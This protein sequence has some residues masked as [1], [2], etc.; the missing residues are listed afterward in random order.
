MRPISKE[1][2]ASY[3]FDAF[4]LDP[5]RRMLL[6][7]G[8]AIAL[9]PKVFQTLLVLVRNGRGMDKDELMQQVWPDTVVEEVNLAHN[10]SMLRKALG[11][12][13]DENRFI[14]TVPGRGS[15]SAIVRRPGGVGD[16]AAFFGSGPYRPVCVQ[17]RAR[18]DRTATE[19]L[20][21]RGAVRRRMSDN[22]RQPVEGRVIQH[23]KPDAGISR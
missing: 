5:V 14:I 16:N 12:K 3:Q 21:S 11:Q 17:Y 20:D 8:K 10:I 18:K 19:S 23:C 2:E 15:S 4:D 9:K 6:R 13:A 22:R 1:N 7:E